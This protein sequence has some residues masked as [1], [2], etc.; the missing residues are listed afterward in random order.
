MF[1]HEGTFQAGCPYAQ[2]T[3]DKILYNIVEFKKNR[4]SRFRV[5]ADNKENE[6]V[7]QT[8]FAVFRALVGP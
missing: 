6:A 5:I 4:R 2:K 8:L 1:N 7:V 3:R